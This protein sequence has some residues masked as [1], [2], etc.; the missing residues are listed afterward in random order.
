MDY[1]V[2]G[3]VTLIMYGDPRLTHDIDV[4]VYLHRED[5]EILVQTFPSEEFYCSPIEVIKL[6]IY[7]PLRGHF[8]KNR[9]GALC[10]F[11]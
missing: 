10:E 4:V 3:A 1:M 11:S 5:A 6:E 9:G 7:R 8:N 2:T